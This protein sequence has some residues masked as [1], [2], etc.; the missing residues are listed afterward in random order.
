[1]GSGILIATANAVTIPAGVPIISP[2]ATAPAVSALADND[3][4]FRTAVPDGLQGAVLGRI[5]KARGVDRVAVMALNNDYGRGLA[6]A[7]QAA[8]ERHGGTVT[9]SQN[10]EA[11][12]PS[13]RAELQTIAGRGNPQ[14][15]L[16]IG[17][18]GSGG[19]TILRNAVENGF[20]TRFILPDG[21]RD[22][23]VIQA[24]GAGPM[25]N[26][27]GTAPGS[28]ASPERR[29]AYVEAF[30]RANPTL[31]PASAF[32]AQAYDA[33]Y[34][35]ALAIQKAGRA[36]RAA[37]RAALRQV[38]N[39]P[40]E[41]VG[42]GEWAKAK[43]ALTAG[44]EVDYEGASGPVNFN[45]TGDAEGKIEVWAVTEGRIATV[46]TVAS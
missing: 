5:T 44:R 7:F 36:D 35:A 30:R 1:M 24:V 10:F 27:F 19:I 15:L 13:Y 26:T 29:A 39:A 11:D 3:T 6:G 25:A 38:A 22:Q 43:A 32:V 23:A 28:A 33:T 2:S 34:V 4:V 16:V 46:E 45:D 18:P 31:D 20:F 14:A 17:Y 12:R 21:M 8:F 9:A 40:G 37:I 41:V 42:P